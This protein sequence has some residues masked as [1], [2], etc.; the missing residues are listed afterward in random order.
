MTTIIVSLA[1]LLVLLSVTYAL[2]RVAHKARHD[3]YG[4]L[5]ELDCACRGKLR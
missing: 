3:S 4:W 2:E 5:C 1:A